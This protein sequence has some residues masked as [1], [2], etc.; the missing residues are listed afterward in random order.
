[1]L[2][3]SLSQIGGDVSGADEMRRIVAPVATRIDPDQVFTVFRL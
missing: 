1:M 2:L 3:V